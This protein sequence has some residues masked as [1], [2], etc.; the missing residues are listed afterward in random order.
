MAGEY[1]WDP[2]AMAS[3]PAW[4][5]ARLGLYG[6]SIG[7]GRAL[8]QGGLRMPPPANGGRYGSPDPGMWAAFN[9]A[10]GGGAPGGGGAR[11]AAAQQMYGGGDGNISYAQE[12]L[13]S[14]ELTSLIE[15]GAKVAP[16]IA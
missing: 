13:F 11:A 15:F 7:E 14:P 16:L 4:E 1:S 12:S 2:A 6:D 8:G 10:F 3:S 9:R 5:K